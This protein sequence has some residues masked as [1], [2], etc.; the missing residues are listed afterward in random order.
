MIES[1]SSDPPSHPRDPAD[2]TVVG[3]GIVATAIALEYRRRRPDARIVLVGPDT[4][5]GAASPASAAMLA[6]YSELQAG[7]LENPVRRDR[8][9]L[10]RRGAAR[11]PDWIRGFATRIG[12]PTPTIR[13]GI[14][15]VGQESDETLATIE[16][17]ARGDGVAAVRVD[18][19]TIPGYHP[20]ITVRHRSAIR[21]ETEASIDPIAALAVLD[22]AV[23]DAGI[24]RIDD[25]VVSL[26]P[27]TARLASSGEIPIGRVVVANGAAAGRLLESRPDL[28]TWIPGIAF[29]VGV[30]VRARLH[31]GIRVPD[32]VVRTP[33]TPDGHGTYFVPHGPT[34][35]YVGATNDAAHEPRMF[36]RVE[37][38]RA[39]V[40]SAMD[41]FSIDL[42]EAEC[43]PVVGHRPL[44][45]DGAPVLGRLDETTW[46]AT[47]T[48]RDGLTCAPEIAARLVE[49]M[50][51]GEDRFPPGVRPRRIGSGNR[52]VYS[53]P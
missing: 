25:L 15:V 7:D 47:G 53:A 43:R 12:M 32:R 39:L 36:P 40:E 42:G 2:L 21:I 1:M 26:E 27:G 19:G 52:G 30:A 13:S 16:E 4:R 28:A 24:Q 49:S 14:V 17:A 45:T 46:I 41:Q 20:R 8:F 6:A 3:N 9:E 11:W 44:T 33:N 37:E 38:L 31:P 29:G 5:P 22:R 18:P 23:V 51:S 34:T 35:C 48:G 10:A 50:I